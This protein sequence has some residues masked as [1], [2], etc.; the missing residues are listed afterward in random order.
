MSECHVHEKLWIW[1]KNPIPLSETSGY[2]SLPPASQ[3]ARASSSYVRFDAS[4]REWL[5]RSWPPPPGKVADR[6]DFTRLYDWVS[7]AVSDARAATS[8]SGTAHYNAESPAVDGGDPLAQ[9]AAVLTRLHSDAFHELVRLLSSQE[10]TAPVA[11]AL[12]H[13]A[14]SGQL[15]T[16]A[17]EVEL[18]T[19]LRTWADL[20]RKHK[21]A[22]AA[23]SA[24]IESDRALVSGMTDAAKELRAALRAAGL[25]A[26]GVSGGAPAPAAAAA[27]AA[28]RAFFPPRAAAGAGQAHAAATWTAPASSPTRSRSP[29]GTQH[30]ARASAAASPFG[31]SSTGSR[32]PLMASVSI[33]ESARAADTAQA[34]TAFAHRAADVALAADA[35]DT[36]TSFASAAS[37]PPTPRFRNAGSG[38]T[39]NEGSASPGRRVSEGSAGNGDDHGDD[40]HHDDHDERGSPSGSPR[41]LMRKDRSV[42]YGERALTGGLSRRVT[43]SSDIAALLAAD[44]DAGDSGGISSLGRHHHDVD[45]RHDGEDAE[46]HESV[47]SLN[48]DENL[49]SHGESSND[50]DSSYESEG[51]SESQSSHRSEDSEPPSAVAPASATGGGGAAGS[52]NGSGVHVLS[53]ADELDR[54]VVMLPPTAPFTQT[55]LARAQTAARRRRGASAGSSSSSE[56]GGKKGKRGGA[57]DGDGGS[58]DSD[59][60]LSDDEGGRVDGASKNDG[61][62]ASDADGAEARLAALD[63][64]PAVSRIA[65]RRRMREAAARHAEK[66]ARQQARRAARRAARAAAR[67]LEKEA[68]AAARRSSQ[69]LL[70]GKDMAAAVMGTLPQLTRLFASEAAAVTALKA[71]LGGGGAPAGSDGKDTAASVKKGAAAS[72]TASASTTPLMSAADALMDAAALRREA[73]ALIASLRGTEAALARRLPGAAKPATKAADTQTQWPEALP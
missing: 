72:S 67:K 46:E 17:C 40:G 36:R 14:L 51:S 6:G 61:T 1:S 66:E 26:D 59:A 34:A 2:L 58:S 55:A 35:D 62:G 15:L 16:G 38:G 42:S 43:S 31:G 64:H 73:L 44:A 20:G 5:T 8:S 53:T 54:V 49:G 30:V 13:L 52:G 37:R 56:G 11:A 29:A 9:E 69:A 28:Q 33:S 10:R 68:E 27:A 45:A 71:Q 21:D 70:V 39:D 65:S 32:P 23:A 19:L 60:P 41:Q 24:Q 57:G 18:L 47:A 25:L 12:A 48:T 50:D 63:G 3:L 4:T 22:A 7:T